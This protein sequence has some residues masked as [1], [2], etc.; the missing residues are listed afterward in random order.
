VIDDRK[1][2]AKTAGKS[3]RASRYEA[4]RTNPH[5]TDAR[6]SNTG[7]WVVLPNIGRILNLLANWASPGS[8]SLKEATR[9]GSQL[10]HL[11]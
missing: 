9:R 4:T 8:R 10:A 1:I 2:K 5:F 6:P 3:K 11:S 7:F